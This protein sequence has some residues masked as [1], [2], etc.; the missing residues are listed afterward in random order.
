MAS[1][2]DPLGKRALFDS[3]HVG[4]PPAAHEAEPG[5]G[6]VTIDC[7]GCGAVRHVSRLEALREVTRWPF[8][9]V[10]IRREA[11]WMRCD[12]CGNRTWNRV[13]WR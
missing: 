3:G 13:E 2:Q 9:W 12:A 1:R 6:L 4:E 8:L 10:P 7:A 5:F 11:H